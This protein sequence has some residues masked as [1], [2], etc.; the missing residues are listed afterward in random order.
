MEEQE[1]GGDEYEAIYTSIQ[2]VAKKFFSNYDITGCGRINREEMAFLLRDLGDPLTGEELQHLYD[3]YDLV[4]H[5]RY[6]SYIYR[7]VMDIFHLKN[8]A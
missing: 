4:Y 8:S 5:T 6:R 1:N 2:R 3:Q 7:T